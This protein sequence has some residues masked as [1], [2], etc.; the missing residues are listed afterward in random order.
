MSVK[1]DDFRPVG[2]CKID[3]LISQRKRYYTAVPTT[4]DGEQK[5]EQAMQRTLHTTL[6]N[7]RSSIPSLVSEAQV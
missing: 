6:K 2:T 4:P 3:A 7:I 1:I 5:V